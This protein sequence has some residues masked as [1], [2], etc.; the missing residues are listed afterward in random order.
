MDV[1][2]EN[3]AN[4]NTTR[5]AN[6]DPYRR[7]MVIFQEKEN[8]AF[9][10][11]LVNEESKYSGSGVRVTSIEED[12]SPFKYVYEPGHPDAQPDGYVRMPNVDM[13][14]EMMDMIS[15]TRSYEANVT[16]INATKSMAMKALEIG[17]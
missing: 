13:V 9:S 10:S 6:G 3:I 7:K 5:T 17:R 15:A 1:I 16:S 8:S 14:K 12:T 4:A 11:Y 2:S